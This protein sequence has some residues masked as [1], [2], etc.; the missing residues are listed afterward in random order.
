MAFVVIVAGAELGLFTRDGQAGKVDGNGGN[1]SSH[2]A[3][4]AGTDVRRV[5]VATKADLDAFAGASLQL[6]A[7]SCVLRVAIGIGFAFLI[8]FAQTPLAATLLGCRRVVLCAGNEKQEKAGVE[9]VNCRENL[10]S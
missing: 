1:G 4:G 10:I 6:L 3:L 7:A 2:S 8:P 5:R 9:S